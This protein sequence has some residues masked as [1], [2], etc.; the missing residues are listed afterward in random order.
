MRLNIWNLLL[1][2]ALTLNTSSAKAGNGSDFFRELVDELAKNDA[3][4]K[5]AD[6]ISIPTIHGPIPLGDP[7]GAVPPDCHPQEFQRRALL[8]FENAHQYSQFVQAYFNRCG[9]FLTEGNSR[10]IHALLKFAMTEYD[11]SQNPQ[12]KK[13]DLSLSDGSKVEAY[14]GIKDLKTVRPWVIVKCGVFCDITSSAS[15]LNFVINLFDQ[16]PFN[17]IFLSNHTGNTNIKLNGALTLGGFYEVYDLYDIAHWL[18]YQSPYRDTVDSVHATGVSLGG[19]AAMAVSHLSSLYRSREGRPIFS[20]TTAVCPVVNLGPT[21]KDMYSNTTKGKLFTRLTWKYLKDASP[22][23]LDAQDY[24]SAKNPPTAEKFPLM[25]SDI[26]LRYGTRWERTSPPGRS[27][28]TTPGTINEL[29]QLNHFSLKTPRLEVPTLAWGSH[30][31][32]VVS[33]DLN[34]K[35]LLESSE[36]GP[37]QGAVGVNFGDHCG[38]DTTYGFSA[39]TAVLQSF[40]LNNSPNF[41]SR[42]HQ[43]SIAY[44]VKPPRFM[45]GEI[46]LRQ[47]W[48][49]E[50]KKDTVTVYFETFNPILGLACR[51]VNPFDSTSSC[52]RTYSQKI[53]IRDLQELGA[54]VPSN[55]TEAQILSRQ[56]NHLIRLTQGGQAID[57]TIFRPSAITWYDY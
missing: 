14:I 46:H 47:W 54:K 36:Q 11:L 30:D 5:N 7:K 48:I 12:I 23:L 17:A 41:K 27:S 21:L 1:S 9:N 34:T 57:G 42:R 39:T 4:K 15:S 26:V 24:L 8:N 18:K 35:T 32:H 37:D 45:H 49:A 50:E 13:E 10:G 51:L 20:S 56:L 55:A 29:M 44:P 52:R 31:D 25:L 43:R 22:Y 2:A 40:I 28:A 53:A 33:F 6:R 19:S 3:M 38:F 16:S